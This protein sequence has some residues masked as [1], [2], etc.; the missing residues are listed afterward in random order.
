MNI[1]IIVNKYKDW[2]DQMNVLAGMLS[3]EKGIYQDYLFI[4]K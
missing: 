1:N 4:N 2:L 3:Q